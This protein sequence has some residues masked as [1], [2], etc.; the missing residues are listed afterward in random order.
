MISLTSP[1]NSMTM[2]EEVAV[3]GCPVAEVAG[4]SLFYLC[5]SVSSALRVYW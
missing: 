5:S 4:F 3:G 1:N 2:A